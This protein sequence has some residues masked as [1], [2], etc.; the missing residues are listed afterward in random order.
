MLYKQTETKSRRN[1]IIIGFISMRTKKK[2][3]T[4]FIKIL[5]L[6]N[7][8]TFTI[9]YIT[10]RKVNVDKF[11]KI[12]NFSQLVGS[13]TMDGFIGCIGQEEARYH[14]KRSN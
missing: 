9:T 14:T 7:L 6:T 2:Q 4:H 1:L 13:V 10:L 12:P 5:T 11:V 8:S 3:K